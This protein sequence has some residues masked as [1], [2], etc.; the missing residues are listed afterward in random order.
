MNNNDLLNALSGIDPKYIDEAALELHAEQTQEK[1]TETDKP[2]SSAPAGHADDS[3]VITSIETADRTRIEKKIRTRRLISIVIPAAAV[4]LFSM[5]VALPFIIR[6]GKS[7]SS[8]PAASDSASYSAM[9]EAAAD[10]ASYD[11]AEAL[12]DTAPAYESAE[13]ASDTAPAY[14]AEEPAAEAA[15]ESEYAEADISSASESAKAESSVK[16]DTS[17]SNMNTTGSNASAGTSAKDSDSSS[18]LGLESAE[19][20][21]GVL[22]VKMSGTLPENVE[23]IEYSITGADKTGSEKIYAEG[24]I[25]DI[26]TETDPLTLDISGS[27]LPAGTY[28]LSIGEETVEFS[29]K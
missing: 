8:A 27:A 3:S 20:A 5:T 16:P 22:T 12:A 9:E 24:K 13:A 11:D 18:A 6:N 19:Y 28:T 2:V 7:E 29:V 23:T 21:D 25:S 17:A 14:N 15:S 1:A 4:I 10:T 26:L